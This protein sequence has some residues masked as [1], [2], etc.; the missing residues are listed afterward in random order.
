MGQVLQA[1]EAYQTA[2][3][4]DPENEEAAIGLARA[5]RQIYNYNETRRLLQRA[6]SQHIKSG[7]ALVELGRL[8]IHLQHY[9]QAAE[10]L[11]EAVQRDP[12]LVA[13]YVNLGVAYQAKGDQQKALE[14]F[15]AGQARVLVATDIAAGGACQ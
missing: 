13:A 6:S 5:Y 1:I 2:L 15:R 11:R 12:A 8:D 7:A 4:L 14:Q 9:D 3:K 10:E